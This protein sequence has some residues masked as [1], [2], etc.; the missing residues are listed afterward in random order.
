MDSTQQ[1]IEQ[2]IKYVQETQHKQETQHSIEQYI[3]HHK[4]G[5]INTQQTQQQP[6]L[7]GIIN[8]NNNCYVISVLQCLINDDDFIKHCQKKS[9][10]YKSIDL[11]LEIANGLLND[12]NR[13]KQ[14]LSTLGDQND[15]ELSHIIYK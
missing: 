9:K 1:S 10:Q 4:Q 8:P 7:H 12:S 15:K 11:L 13:I 14:I 5:Q 6:Q 2:Y 3:Q